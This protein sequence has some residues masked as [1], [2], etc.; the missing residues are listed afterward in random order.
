MNDTA[1]RHALLLEARKLFSEKG[2]RGASI[3]E[4]TARAGANLGAVTYHFGSK[5][6][7]HHAVLESV[8]APLATA[9]S[10]LEARPGPPLE[11]IDEL[12]ALLLRHLDRHPADAGLIRHELAMERTLPPPARRWLGTL[13]GTLGRLIREGQAQGS[14]VAGDPRLLAATVLAQP[15]YFAMARHAL[16]QGAGIPARGARRDAVHDHIRRAVRRTL[17]VE[18]RPS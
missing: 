14:I 2:Y 1:T 5:E 17:E 4:L 9:L 6:A 13:F 16:A 11:R 3:R 7:L 18:R 12:L 15:F 8:F 10:A